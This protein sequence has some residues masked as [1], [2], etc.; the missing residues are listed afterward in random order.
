M[1][2]P[3]FDYTTAANGLLNCW[4]NGHLAAS[5][6]GRMGYTPA[7]V[8]GQTGTLDGCD[9]HFGLYGAKTDAL[10]KVYFSQVKLADNFN[11]AL[12]DSLIG[13]NPLMK[14]IPAQSSGGAGAA[15]HGTTADI[16]ASDIISATLSGSAP[17]PGKAFYR[18]EPFR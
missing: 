9:V 8:G 5:W 16:F 1:I 6:K 13:A 15:L 12:P 17:P 4:V 10:R 3:K 14:T 2:Q 11:E 18:I 7:S